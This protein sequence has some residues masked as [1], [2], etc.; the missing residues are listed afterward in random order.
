M[1]NDPNR[2][3]RYPL[4]WPAWLA[5]L[6][7]Q[8]ANDRTQSVAVYIREAVLQKLERDGYRETHHDHLH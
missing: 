4:T 3:I 6:A 5:E 1:S 2:N 7:A 8:A